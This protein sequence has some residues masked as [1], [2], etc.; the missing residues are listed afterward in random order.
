MALGVKRLVSQGAIDEERGRAI[1]SEL[2]RVANAPDMRMIT[3]GVL[4]VVARK[5]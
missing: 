5:R 3:P 1:E 4:E 2:D